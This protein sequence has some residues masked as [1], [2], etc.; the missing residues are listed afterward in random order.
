MDPN[1]ALQQI[2]EALLDNDPACAEEIASGLYAWIDTG[3]FLPDFKAHP[4]ALKFYRKFA[5]QQRAAARLI[6]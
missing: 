4:L 3:G 1:A 6:R 2:D 5:D